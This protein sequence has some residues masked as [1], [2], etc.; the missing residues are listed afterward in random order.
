MVLPFTLTVSTYQ[1]V[2]ATLESVPR[3]QRN[4]TFPP[5][6]EAGRLAVVVTKPPELP[7]QAERP[8]NGLLYLIEMVPL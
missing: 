2:P 1:P 5:A 3:R 7:V 6:A 4:W 8:A